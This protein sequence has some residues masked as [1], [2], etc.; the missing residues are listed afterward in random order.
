[1]RKTLLRIS[2][3]SF[4]AAALLLASCE[5]PTSSDLSYAKIGSVENVKVTGYL[6]VNLV[7]WDPVV[8][9]ESY[10][11]YR[12][13]KPADKDWGAYK[14]LT[15]NASIFYLDTISDSNVLKD[16]SEYTYKVVANAQNHLET[17]G[18]NYGEKS[19]KTNTT[20]FPAATPQ[21]PARDTPLGITITDPQIKVDNTLGIATLTWTVDTDNPAISYRLLPSSGWTSKSSDK[22][23]VTTKDINGEG[24]VGVQIIASFNNSNYYSASTPKKVD[25]VEYN[26]QHL[27]SITASLNSAT[28]TGNTNQVIINYTKVKEATTYILQKAKTNSVNA[29]LSWTDVATTDA[30]DLGTSFTVTDTIDADAYQYRLFVRTANGISIA[31]TED[32]SAV[33]ATVSGSISASRQLK[34]ADAPTS[35]DLD[36]SKYEIDF[37][38]SNATEGASYQL[39]YRKI[40]TSNQTKTSDPNEIGE[41]TSGDSVTAT[42]V[43]LTSKVFHIYFTPPA[44]RQGYEYKIVGT[45]EGETALQQS[46]TSITNA[47]SVGSNGFAVKSALVLSSFGMPDKTHI[48]FTL[49][50][51]QANETIQVYAQK[52]ITTTATGKTAIEGVTLIGTI[53]AAA[54]APTSLTITSPGTD[55]GTTTYEWKNLSL[56]YNAK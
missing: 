23:V 56:V 21:F 26:V 36:D 49:S 53:T 50:G 12:K 24:Y 46:I 55:T 42:G 41:W 18:S 28:R 31:S 7:T 32:V 17:V 40:G 38:I 27:D 4:V 51:A 9:A 14:S 16:T 11:V 48:T 19:Y 33:T 54:A 25:P 30:V 39:Q 3:S 29:L 2:L 44:Q 43:D 47:T 34:T 6:G 22:K 37:S 15:T 1:M 35:D 20:D 10:S 5:Q 8:D 52:E 13:E 45:K